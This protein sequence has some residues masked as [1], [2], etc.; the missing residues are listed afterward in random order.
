MSTV[1]VFDSQIAKAA[2][3]IGQF[4][5]PHSSF[6]IHAHSESLIHG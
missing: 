1:L 4:L 2:L 3:K 5:I 6:L